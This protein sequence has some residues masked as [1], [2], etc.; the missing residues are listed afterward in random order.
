[1]CVQE[2]SLLH[3]QVTAYDCAKGSAFPAHAC[4][5]EAFR[6]TFLQ[7]LTVEGALG[8]SL[9]HLS[10]MDRLLWMPTVD[11]ALCAADTPSVFLHLSAMCVGGGVYREG[12]LFRI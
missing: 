1:M 7:A 4:V 5:R 11:A 3:S 10:D 9:P 12:S 2:P 8:S 6:A